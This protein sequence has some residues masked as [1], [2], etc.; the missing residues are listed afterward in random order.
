M[1]LLRK[2]SQKSVGFSKVVRASFYARLL[3][4]SAA[5]CVHR[6]VFR[7]FACRAA[8]SSEPRNASNNLDRPKASGTSTWRGALVGGQSIGPPAPLPETDRIWSKV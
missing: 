4:C 6:P 1:L 3:R 2:V 8:I 5:R 7:H